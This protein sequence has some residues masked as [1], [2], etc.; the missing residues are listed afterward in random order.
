[1]QHRTL[2]SKVEE[3][4]QGEKPKSPERSNL[5]GLHKRVSRRI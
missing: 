3:A 2:G 4:F 5:S 1:M